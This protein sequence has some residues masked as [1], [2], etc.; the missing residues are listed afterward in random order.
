M[1]SKSKLAKSLQGI[2]GQKSEW[3]TKKN[4]LIISDLHLGEGLRQ[5]GV[6]AG[7]SVAGQGGLSEGPNYEH[8]HRLEMELSAF[9]THYTNER[10]GG[11]P[12]RL[13]INGDMVDFMSIMLFPRPQSRPEPSQ[14]VS[15]MRT[16]DDPWG[17]AEVFGLGSGALDSAVKLERVIDHHQAL[18]R[19]LSTFIAAGND[20][21]VVLGN[22]DMEFTHPGVQ[23]TFVRRLC[24]LNQDPGIRPRVRFCPWFYYEQDL[25]YVE[26]GHQYDEYCSFD[27]QLC[28][29]ASSGSLALSFAH[30]GMRF[31]GN[32]VPSY[33]QRTAER[34]GIFDYVRWGLSL[35]VRPMIW[36]AY[37]YGLLAWKASEIGTLLRHPKEETARRGRHQVQLQ[38]LSQT[39]RIQEEKLIALDRLRMIP[40]VR[41]LGKIFAVLFIDRMLLGLL[42][43][44][45]L[46]TLLCLVPGLWKLFSTTAVIGA[47]VFAN[48]LLQRF[49]GVTSPHALRRVTR[50][51]QH[52]VKAPFIV[53][54]HSH[55]PEK[56]ALDD[57]AVYYNTGT[58][59]EGFNAHTGTHLV[60][61]TDVEVPHAEMRKWQDGAPVRIDL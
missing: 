11:R 60:V 9:L 2:R 6:L 19:F 23:E 21:V 18:F 53:F 61:L 46:V 33:D 32:L 43:V 50:A 49:R 4:L 56:V 54:G 59:M 42:S 55:E 1:K 8:L 58:W 25:I 24:E 16:G 39:F 35:G 22:H 48:Y 36:L 17:A 14:V 29:A 52:I 20:L 12:W 45:L 10:I 30:T 38:A 26:H 34:W 5:E 51:I 31:F 27:Y 13:I 57:G 3:K 40:A 41:R 47:A 28:P 37:M 44:G 7:G 15:S